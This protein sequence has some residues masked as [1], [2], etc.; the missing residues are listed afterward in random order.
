MLHAERLGEGDG[1]RGGRKKEGV[2]DYEAY[3]AYMEFLNRSFYQNYVCPIC[4]D[5]LCLS[6]AT[7]TTTTIKFVCRPCFTRLMEEAK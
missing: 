3:L 2:M 4:H 6:N 1:Q 7:N 5:A